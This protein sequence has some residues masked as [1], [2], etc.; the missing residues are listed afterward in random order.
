[1]FRCEWGGSGERTGSLSTINKKMLR[2]CT[3]TLP[4]SLTPE[5][6]FRVHRSRAILPEATERCKK[7]DYIGLW[8]V[9][10][11]SIYHHPEGRGWQKK[12]SNLPRVSHQ[13]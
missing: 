12:P 9:L 6:E 2:V 5:I 1:M 7:L 3:K 8:S 11:A 13:R 10:S 4:L